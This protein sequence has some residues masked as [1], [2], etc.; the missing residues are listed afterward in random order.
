MI[1]ILGLLDMYF[2]AVVAEVKT[3]LLLFILALAILR[4]TE[5]E[6][7]RILRFGDLTCLTVVLIISRVAAPLIQRQRYLITL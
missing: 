5:H 3:F 1:Q 7:S 4:L 6:K 2:D